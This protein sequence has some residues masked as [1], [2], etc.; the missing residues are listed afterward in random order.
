ME[1]SEMENSSSM[2]KLPLL[3]LALSLYLAFLLMLYTGG[4]QLSPRL[5]IWWGA[6]PVASQTSWLWSL[7]SVQG[8][9]RVLLGAAVVIGGLLA[10]GGRRY[11]ST[12]LEVLLRRRTLVR[13][14]FSLIVV[15]V[16]WYFRL[17]QSLG[18]RE[19]YIRLLLEGKW[20]FM[21]QPLTTVIFAAVYRI[22]APFGWAPEPA[23]ALVNCV[24]GGAWT[25]LLLKLADT[26]PTWKGQLLIVATLLSG[27]MT[28]FFGFIEATPVP[29]VVA[30]LYIHLARCT[31]EGRALW[32]AA[33]TVGMAV[34][35]HGLMLILVPSFFMLCFIVWRRGER[36]SVLLGTLLAGLPALLTVGYALTHRSLIWGTVYGDSLGGGD[37]RM[38]VPLFDTVTHFEHYTLFS[39]GHLMELANLALLVAPWMG[40]CVVPALLTLWRRRMQ[41]ES[42]FAAALILAPLSF[43]VLWN[44]DL[45]MQYDWDLFTPPLLIATIAAVL[46]WPT[47]R[48]KRWPPAVFGAALALNCVTLGLLVARLSPVGAW[49]PWH[50]AGMQAARPLEARFGKSIRLTHYELSEVALQPG[51]SV[52]VTLY[53]HT[54][55]P[56]TTDYTAFVHLVRVDGAQ[57]QLI[58]QDDHPPQSTR[59]FETDTRR[60]SSAW[61]AGEVVR[62]HHTLLI[63]TSTPPGSYQLWVGLYQLDA[64]ERLPV[65]GGAP[66]GTF[67]ELADIYIGDL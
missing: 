64:M 26:L 63:P 1:Q 12:I 27:G 6:T 3:S 11:G 21:S 20:F 4:A 13:A 29:L 35:L 30:L 34:A 44:P 14:G 28:L 49:S 60:S 50:V 66:E 33:L 65:T 23:I 22:L 17:W 48:H 42:W 9:R 25:F 59:R 16:L 51:E 46:A 55:R 36:R 19:N 37:E 56:L 45:G 43:V 61:T 39:K 15:T 38:F 57:P 40:M 7:D 58:A 24:A 54:R 52:T 32:P 2:R 5:D 10:A 67:I 31:L 8:G 18:D 53:W 62:D 47:P 41:P